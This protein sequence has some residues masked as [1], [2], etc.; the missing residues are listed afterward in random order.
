MGVSAGPPPPAPLP[1]LRRIPV[2]GFLPFPPFLLA[3][4]LPTRPLPFRRSATAA[5]VTRVAAARCCP[6]YLIFAPNQ[7][8]MPL[9]SK[10]SLVVAEQLR[11]RRQTDNRDWIHGRRFDSQRQALW[12]RKRHALRDLVTSDLVG[13]PVVHRVSCCPWE[14]AHAHAHAHVHAHVTCCT[15]MCMLCMLGTCRKHPPVSG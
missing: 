12:T 13:M 15:C 14:H 10:F 1:A 6:S 3:L 7:S 5:V 2:P 11:V 8:R 4:D 9:H